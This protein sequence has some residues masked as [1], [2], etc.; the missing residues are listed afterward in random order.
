MGEGVVVVGTGFGCH[1]HL[2]AIRRAG[3]TV[4]ALVGRDVDRTRTRAERFGVPLAT[5]SLEEALSL[6][7]TSAVAVVTPPHTHHALVRAA[8]EAGKHVVCEKPFA[9]DTAEARS[10]LE[11]AERAGVVHFLGTEFRFETSQALAN[12]LI[13]DGAIGEPR[14]ATYLLIMPLLADPAAR[15]PDWWAREEDG[16]GWLGAQ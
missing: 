7:D 4:S 5:T 8:V 3:L 15:V 10:M 14:L 11:A 2:R 9:R 12:R 13:A 1:T 6:P 16:G